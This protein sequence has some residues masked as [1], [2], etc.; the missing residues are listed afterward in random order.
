[1]MLNQHLERL[2]LNAMRPWETSLDEYIRSAFPA[3]V[4]RPLWS[5]DASVEP[6]ALAETL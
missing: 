5:E 6:Y 1:M 3:L 2:G 4:A